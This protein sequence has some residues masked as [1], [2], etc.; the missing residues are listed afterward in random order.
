[1]KPEETILS[2]DKLTIGYPTSRVGEIDQISFSV[3]EIF[4]LLGPNGCGKTTLFKTLL[5]LIP[6]LAGE[7]RLNDQNL[8]DLRRDELAKRLAYVPQSLASPFAFSVEEIVVMGRNAHRSAFAPPSKKD[9]QISFE[10]L[11]LMGIAHLA[12]RQ[13][14]T[15]SGGQRQLVGIARAIAQE[16]SIIIMDEPTASLDFG[17]QVMVLSEIRKLAARGLGIVMS[18]HN[19]D[20]ALSLSSRVALMNHGRIVV[21]GLANDVL[22]AERIREVYGVEVCMEKMSNGSVVCVPKLS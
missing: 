18:T 6:P 7:V 15:L 16:S 21:S 5:G 10:A 2:A 9:R 11:G 14:T 19:P 1:M 3:G 17:N 4:C 20:H 12:H 22:T 13:V 8:S